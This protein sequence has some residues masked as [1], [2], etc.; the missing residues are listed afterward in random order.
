MLSQDPAPSPAAL[1]AIPEEAMVPFTS[2]GVS[3]NLFLSVAAKVA[4]F[5][6]ANSWLRVVDHILSL[7]YSLF[8]GSIY[9]VFLCYWAL[10]HVLV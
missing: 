5:M 6:S 4:T 2:Y 3:A 7:N 1:F 8:I 10:D 9:T